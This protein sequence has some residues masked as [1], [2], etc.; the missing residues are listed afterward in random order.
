[1]DENLF[2]FSAAIDK[3]AKLEQER[4]NT[5]HVACQTDNFVVSFSCV[6]KSWA[7]GAVQAVVFG[8]LCLGILACSSHATCPGNPCPC[9][10]FLKPSRRSDPLK[11]P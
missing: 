5:V 1:M 9:T 4:H 6:E 8:F 3:T 11:P 2:S 7:T 10:C